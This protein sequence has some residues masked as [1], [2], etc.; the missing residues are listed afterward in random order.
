MSLEI[1]LRCIVYDSG[2]FKFLL[3]SVLC[4][5]PRHPNG[6]NQQLLQKCL[7]VQNEKTT[8]AHNDRFFLLGY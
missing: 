1:E 3:N 6:T 7:I 4:E 2:W 5:M 8:F